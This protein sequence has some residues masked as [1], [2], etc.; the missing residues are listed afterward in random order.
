[1]KWLAVLFFSVF[2][3]SKASFPQSTSEQ[4]VRSTLEQLRQDQV[5]NDVNAVSRLYA[6]G[7]VALNPDGTMANKASRVKQ[8]T[9]RAVKIKS[10]DFS[11]LNIR[12]YGDTAIV[13]GV[14][15]STSENGAPRSLRFMQVWVKQ[16]SVWRE[17]ALAM[18]NMKSS[19]SEQ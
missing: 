9:E 13:T 14:S 5:H 10:L 4:E 12:V 11:D 15:H 3:F 19:T 1:M 18:A 6:D 2:L 7:F 8:L 16:D 17:T